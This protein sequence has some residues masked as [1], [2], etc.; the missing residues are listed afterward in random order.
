MCCVCRI[1]FNKLGRIPG[2]GGGVA[3]AGDATMSYPGLAGT[4]TRPAVAITGGGTGA[5][6]DVR[7][8]EPHRDDGVGVVVG[9]GV[10]IPGGG[11]IPRE[12]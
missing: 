10:S 5:D 7:A 1:S 6:D 9:V 3:D 11:A 8:P 2:G 12:Y 4:F